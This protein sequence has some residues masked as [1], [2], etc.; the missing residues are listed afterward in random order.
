VEGYFNDLK[1]RVLK[2]TPLPLRVDKFI[3]IHIRDILG[4]T[5]L[6]SSKVIT[7]KQRA[8]AINDIQTKNLITITSPA[9]LKQTTRPSVPDC[10]QNPLVESKVIL[11]INDSDFMAQENWREKALNED[12][13]Y[14]VYSIDE[15]TESSMVPILTS[16]Q[17][18]STENST[19][20]SNTESLSDHSYCKKSEL[21]IQQDCSTC[22]T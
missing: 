8:H 5:L 21:N 2:N 14:A 10:N 18:H 17:I 1:T 12:I 22:S 13:G 3:K 9:N 4:Q 19:I 16:T 6:F 15:S 11:N 7:F 20:Q